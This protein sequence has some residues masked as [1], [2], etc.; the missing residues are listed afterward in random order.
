MCRDLLSIVNWPVMFCIGL[1]ICGV[2][3]L[4]MF[5]YR[6]AMKRLP[7]NFLSCLV[8]FSCRLLAR[9]VIHWFLCSALD[10]LDMCSCVFTCAEI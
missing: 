7:I 3:W 9:L 6:L 4:I 10:W 2:D 1:V 8:L 5:C